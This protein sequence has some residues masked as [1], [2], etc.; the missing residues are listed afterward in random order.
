MHRIRRGTLLAA[1]V[2]SHVIA[3][4]AAQAQF[5]GEGT[6]Y[7]DNGWAGWCAGNLPNEGRAWPPY[8]GQQGMRV[9]LNNPQFNNGANCGRTLMFRGT[10]TG[11]T[12]CGMNP[13][14]TAWQK[15]QVTNLC[16]ECKYGDLDMGIAGDGRWKIEWYWLD[17]PP[18]GLT[19]EAKGETRPLAPPPT[20]KPF[21]WRAWLAKKRANRPTMSPQA[22]REYLW[23]SWLA[24]KRAARAAAAAG[25]RKLQSSSHHAAEYAAFKARS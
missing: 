8:G 24:K 19:T 13:I 17:S 4:C 25:R 12:T 10:T 18:A 23:R 2:V 5:Q 6:Y 15:G 3:S 11:C 7:G 1:V 9:A 16:P 20:K 22:R 21:D 14:S